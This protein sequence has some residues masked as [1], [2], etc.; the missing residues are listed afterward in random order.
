MLIRALVAFL[1]LP[2]IVALIAPPLLA[3]IDPWKR[4]VFLPGAIVMFAGLVVTVWCARDF[5]VSGRGTLAPW[6]PPQRLVVVGLYRYTR[7]PMYVGVLLLIAGWALF[8]MSPVLLFYF[9]VLVVAFQ[10]R[11]LTNEEPQCER[12]FGDDWKSYAASV[13]RW[14]PRLT[15]WRNGA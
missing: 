10:I 12:R 7:N 5:Y 13:G 8:Y 11:V 9:A 4:G 6:D 14:I 3:L 2:G 15:P 1:L